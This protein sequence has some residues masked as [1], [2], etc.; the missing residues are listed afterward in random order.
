MNSITNPFNL[1]ERPQKRV[2]DNSIVEDGNESEVLDLSA[3]PIN[4]ISVFGCLETTG[5]ITLK[6]SDDNITFET[7]DY[8]QEAQGC[9][10]FSTEKITSKFARL[11]YNGDVNNVYAFIVT[12]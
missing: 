5:C 6:L 2:F 3:Y 9:F 12:Y 7:T 8:K 11:L 10:G 1:P 4:T